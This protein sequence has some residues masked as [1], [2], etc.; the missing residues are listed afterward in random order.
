MR[1][2]SQL[3][4]FDGCFLFFGD[5]R[6]DS[7]LLNLL[8]SLSQKYERLVLLQISEQPETFVFEHCEVRSQALNPRLRG[9]LKFLRFYCTMLPAV[10]RIKAKFYCAEDVFSL[11]LAY[12]VAQQQCAP[13][14]YDSRELFFALAQLSHK[15]LRQRIWAAIEAH[16][17]RKAKVF[18]SGFRD[19][20]ALRQRYHIALPETIFNYPRYCA[21]SPNSSLRQQLG[22]PD[23]AIILLY[24]GVITDGRGIWKMLD[25]L[26]WLDSRFVA[27]FIG[28]GD[29]L[30]DLQQAIAARHY[31]RR[32]FAIGR[33][34]YQELLPLTASA[35]IGVAL[36]EPLSESY[37]LA[38]PNKLF[39]YVMAGVPV[40]TTDLP[41]MKEIV[42]QHKVGLAV[43]A[44]AD[45][46]SLAEAV[47]TLQSKIEH[48]RHNCQQARKVLNWEAQEAR[49]L[50][51][52]SP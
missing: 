51:F 28:A 41:A 20:E 17:I 7:R 13:L 27:V 44:T 47:I 25:M 26:A 16:C 11:P 32:A 36:I 23:E 43:P 8:R 5:V 33:V 9:A 10:R 12:W 40:L 38:L 52:F 22:L 49:L 18:T 42:E 29:K 1:C 34:P 21:Y 2:A 48:Y 31:H 6:Y 14:Y 19:S 24:Q 3:E 4:L 39:E 35:D 46:K 45:E 15:P 30:G 50:D 37:Q